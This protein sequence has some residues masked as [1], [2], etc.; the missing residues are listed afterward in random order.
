MRNPIAAA[1]L[2]LPEKAA[3]GGGEMTATREADS[4]VGLLLLSRDGARLDEWRR[5]STEEVERFEFG[6][7]M[8]GGRDLKGPSASHPRGRAE[9]ARGVRSSRQGD[10]FASK[11]EQHRIAFV[12]EV[13]SK[14]LAVAQK[15]AWKLVFVLGEPHLSGPAAEVL[16]QGGI[17][18]EQDDRLLG[19]M[20]HHELARAIGPDVDQALL[21]HASGGRSG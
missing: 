5:G 10:L 13:A 12:K 20:T 16:R 6:D 2:E 4:T 7:P 9:G 19:W 17:G 11:L 21:E 14:S 3:R 18:V 8:A 1:I 15:H